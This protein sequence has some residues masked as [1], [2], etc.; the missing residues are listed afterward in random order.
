MKI[1]GERRSLSQF[2]SIESDALNVNYWIMHMA[3][4]IASQK[5]VYEC[6]VFWWG[7]NVFVR[8][9]SSRDYRKMG[10]VFFFWLGRY[11]LSLSNTQQM[12]AEHNGPFV[13]PKPCPWTICGGASERHTHK[14]LHNLFDQLHSFS[15]HVFFSYYAIWQPRTDFC[16]LCLT[17][18]FGISRT[19]NKWAKWSKR[20]RDR[21]NV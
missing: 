18:S 1:S 6:H 12:I 11:L 4:W 20:K 10:I 3:W 8:R 5:S 14:I 17:N 16:W 13:L 21:M 19:Q 15:F 2:L 7:P 9:L